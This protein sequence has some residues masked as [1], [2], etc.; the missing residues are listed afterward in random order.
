MKKSELQQIIRE[1]VRK[2]LNNAPFSPQPVYDNFL[3]AYSKMEKWLTK[4]ISTKQSV[5]IK[6]A[7]SIGFDKLQNTL[8]KN[9]RDNFNL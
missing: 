5:E 3:G 2:S 7:F 6:R 1:E 4:N 8:L 9:N